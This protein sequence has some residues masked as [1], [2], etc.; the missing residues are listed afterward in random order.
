M[1]ELGLF[2]FRGTRIPDKVSTENTMEKL[3]VFI[4]PKAFHDIFKINNLNI[5]DIF[6]YSKIRRFLSFNDLADLVFYN[7]LKLENVSLTNN[8]ITFELFKIIT[9]DERH[10]LQTSVV[11][12]ATTEEIANSCMSILNNTSNKYKEN[13]YYFVKNGNTLFIVLDEGFLGSACNDKNFYSK[14]VRDYVKQLYAM[15][16]IAEVSKLPIFKSYLQVI[17]QQ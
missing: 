1:S 12:L 7:N 14:F 5:V 4:I 10:E 6:N 13:L 8:L 11:P 3:K 16:A 2:A 9:D 17:K 15:V